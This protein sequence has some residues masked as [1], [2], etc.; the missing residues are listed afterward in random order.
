MVVGQKCIILPNNAESEI[1]KRNIKKQEKFKK[2]RQDWNDSFIYLCDKIAA[3][4]IRRE[5]RTGLFCV[6]KW[7]PCL[8]Y[9]ILDCRCTSKCKS[10]EAYVAMM[11][12]VSAYV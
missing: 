2:R 4:F 8:Y 10:M 9:T 7:Q 12:P 5:D 6:I 1:P 11:Y 3:M